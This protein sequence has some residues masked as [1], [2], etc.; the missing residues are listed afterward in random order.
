MTFQSKASG[1]STYSQASV[2]AQVF[3]RAGTTERWTDAYLD[4]SLLLYYPFTV[5]HTDSTGN[6][7]DAAPLTAAQHYDGTTVGGG[8]GTGGVLGRYFTFD[9]V[10]DSIDLPEFSLE[11]SGYAISSWIYPE[12]VVDK[13]FIFY[14][15]DSPP[16]II[17]RI[18]GGEIEFYNND[19]GTRYGI[20]AGDA[21]QTVSPGA[22]SHLV[23]NF[24][25][26]YW[27]AHLNGT[28]VANVY[29]PAVNTEFVGS[30][31]QM[32]RN[33]N[34]NFFSGHM[35]DQRIYD[36]TLSDV[37]IDALYQQGSV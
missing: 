24:D 27:E 31:N 5:A 10:D 22:W 4:D 12:T 35:S 14:L 1:E 6:P 21:S 29:D 18:N 11:P 2:T 36:R 34:G 19:S 8:Y 28:Q 17:V 23:V 3:S 32:G 20:Q 25:G 9:G 16:Q 37:E 7:L 33:P 15:G 13:R 26:E 30:L